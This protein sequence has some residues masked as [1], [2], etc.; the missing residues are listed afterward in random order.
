MCLNSFREYDRWAPRL[1]AVILRWMVALRS[2]VVCSALIF[3]ETL[4]S[5]A[6]GILLKPYV[7]DFRARQIG[8]FTRGFDTL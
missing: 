5:I 6:R 7:G 1:L 8:V 2:L 3:A 4:H